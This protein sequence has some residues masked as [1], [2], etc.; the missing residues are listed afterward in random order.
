MVNIDA[1]KV[2]VERTLQRIEAAENQ[3]DAAG[4]LQDTTDDH[5]VHRRSDTDPPGGPL[6]STLSADCRSSFVGVG[7]CGIG[8]NG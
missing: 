2:E 7:G 4:V 8:G 3:H 5:V 6:P 1:E